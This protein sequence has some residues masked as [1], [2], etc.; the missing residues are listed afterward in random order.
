M[1]VYATSDWLIFKTGK[2]SPLS[3]EELLQTPKDSSI[4]LDDINK[5]IIHKTELTIRKTEHSHPNIY[6]VEDYP[7]THHET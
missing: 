5:L 7:D 4:L 2:I 3:K 1:G 6:C